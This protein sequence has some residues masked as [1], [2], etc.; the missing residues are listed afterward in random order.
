MADRRKLGAPLGSSCAG[1]PSQRFR[2]AS[3]GQEVVRQLKAAA[4]A[5]VLVLSAAAVVTSVASA[6][7]T[8]AAI[9]EPRRLVWEDHA[10]D[11]KKRKVFRRMYRMEEPV[12]NKVAVLLEPILQRN[13]YYARTERIIPQHHRPP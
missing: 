12:F 1:P 4:T 11:L 8:R 6:N 2:R 9:H 7:K 5:V 10:A 3:G 13:D